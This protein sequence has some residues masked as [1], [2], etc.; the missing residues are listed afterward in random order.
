[1]SDNVAV[2]VWH[3]LWGQVYRRAEHPRLVL[4]PEKDAAKLVADKSYVRVWLSEFWLAA[5]RSWTFGRKPVVKASAQVLYGKPDKRAPGT[6]VLE[7]QTFAILVKPDAG[8]GVF[9]DYRITEWLPYRGQPVELEAA[10]YSVLGKNRLLTAI[11][12]LSEFAAL[13]TPPISAALSVADRVSAGVEKVIRANGTEPRLP[14]HTS[15]TAPGW[16]AVVDAPEDR[17]PSAELGVNDAGQLCWNGKQV[18]G[19]NYLVLRVESC[20]ERGDWRTPDLDM[21]I[22]AALNARDIDGAKEAYKRLYAEALSKVY[23]S[24]DFT[25]IQRK[26]VAKVV[27]EELDDTSYGAV[28]D[29]GVTLAEIVARHGLPSDSDVEFLTLDELIA[30]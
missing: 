30:G 3:W 1:M 16:V 27:K 21:A 18:T 26:K 9:K 23:L 5:D 13:V 15:L 29:G 14:L 19:C 7:K 28:G 12:I 11:D 25:Q 4:I 8:R 10:L 6:T 24:P 2:R 20:R 17:L 22:A